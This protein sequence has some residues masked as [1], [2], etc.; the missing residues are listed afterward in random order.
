MTR[1]W[2]KPIAGASLV[3]NLAASPTNALACAPPSSIQLSCYSRTSPLVGPPPR[4]AVCVSRIFRPAPSSLVQVGLQQWPAPPLGLGRDARGG[5]GQRTDGGRELAAR[6]PGNLVD[7][8]TAGRL[9]RP[10]AP[11]AWWI[12]LTGVQRLRTAVVPLHIG[13]THR[14]ISSEVDGVKTGHRNERKVILGI[15]Y[16]AQKYSNR[17]HTLASNICAIMKRTKRWI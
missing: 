8:K 2:R 14:P 15:G 11:T 4:Q 9:Q 5:A 6:V 1:V 13:I 16:F 17:Q 12:S 10:Y 7:S 3:Q